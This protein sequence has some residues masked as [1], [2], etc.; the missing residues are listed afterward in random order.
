MRIW[1]RALGLGLSL[2][3]LLSVAGC[4]KDGGKTLASPTPAGVTE[5]D[6]PVDEAVDY[7]KYNAYVTVYNTVYKLSDILECYFEAVA[8]APEFAL[9]EGADYGEI[10]EVYTT[11]ISITYGLKEALKLASE[12]PSYDK[13]DSVTKKLVPDMITLMEQF[14]SLELYM[15]FAEYEEDN[16]EKAA[17]CHT[18][19]YQAADG[20]YQWAASFLDEM[21]ALTEEINDVEME[22]FLKNDELIAYYSNLTIDGAQDVV[23]AVRTQLYNQQEGGELNTEEIAVPYEAF[24]ADSASLLEHMENEDQTAKIP[25]FVD[26]SKNGEDGPTYI[27]YYITSIE[28]LRYYMETLMEQIG[29]QGDTGDAISDVSD[30]LSNL[31][32]R[33]NR[34]IAN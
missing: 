9:L 13:V 2:S 15:V 8:D 34:Y 3:L 12:K 16:Y 21:D 31:I 6:E 14:N 29:S 4:G 30:G 11:D 26:G 20:F 18:E 23:S 33:Y 7:T 5:T 19:I 24:K 28:N 1:S 17:T 25:Y 32:D 10:Q 22:K 27:K